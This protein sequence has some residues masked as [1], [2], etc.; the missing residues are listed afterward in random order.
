MLIFCKLCLTGISIILHMFMS[1][2]MGIPEDH[3]TGSAHS[4]LAPFWLARLPSPTATSGGSSVSPAGRTM[5]TARQC[6]ARG[7]DLTCRV[8]DSRQRVVLSGEA[9]VVIRGTMTVV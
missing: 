2:R 6:S 9:V 4:A 5:M 3:V 7:G 8:D 1:S